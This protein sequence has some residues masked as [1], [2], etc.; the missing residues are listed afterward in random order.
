LRNEVDELANF[1]LGILPERYASRPASMANRIALA[2]LIGWFDL[3]TALLSST[4]SHPNS[5]AI[6]TSEA[7][8]TP[9]STITGTVH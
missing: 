6:A 9:A 8:P 7:V 2:M 5:I 3:A 1:C 4:P